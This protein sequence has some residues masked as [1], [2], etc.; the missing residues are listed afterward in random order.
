[1]NGTHDGQGEAETDGNH[2]HEDGR[3]QE[4]LL[5]PSS[6]G[7]ADDLNLQDQ[8]DLHEDDNQE[9]K[10]DPE[11]GAG[12][13]SRG[14]SGIVVGEVRVNP[15]ELAGEIEDL[16]EQAGDIAEQSQ[17]VEPE[18]GG[19]T[20]LGSGQKDQ[21]DEQ[22][23]GGPEL[24]AIVDADADAVLHEVV[25]QD[26]GHNELTAVG[27]MHGDVLRERVEVSHDAG[28]GSRSAMTGK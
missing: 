23:D 1:M 16:A 17:G 5:I 4:E 18:D 10:D 28:S 12:V 6:N 24:A 8:R 15:D 26:D 27:M 20:L 2:G 3:S 7:S 13:R 25:H 21:D 9:S 14:G 11:H 22:D 19:T